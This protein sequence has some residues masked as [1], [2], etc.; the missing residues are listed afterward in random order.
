MDGEWRRRHAGPRARMRMRMPAACRG[1]AAVL[2][3]QFI[4]TPPPPLERQ[5]AP[6]QLR[7]IAHPH[8]CACM[9]C[10]AVWGGVRRKVVEEVL[11]LKEAG[12]PIP[13]DLL[14]KKK[15]KKAKADKGDKKKK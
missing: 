9:V 12:L 5:A 3:I 10:G 2:A 8:P 1:A 6:C 13:D 15:E 7:M 14:P 11:R 4:L